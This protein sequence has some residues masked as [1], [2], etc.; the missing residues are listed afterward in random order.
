[1]GYLLITLNAAIKRNDR[2]ARIK[3]K[4]MKEVTGVPARFIKEPTIDPPSLSPQPTLV[5]PSHSIS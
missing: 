2:K 4:N 3:I 5:A 1:M